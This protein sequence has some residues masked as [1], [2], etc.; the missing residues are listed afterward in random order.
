ML[1]KNYKNLPRN[2]WALSFVSLLNDTSSEII[3]P[4][5]PTF[6]ALTLGASPLAIGAIEG[7]AETTASLLK[8]FSGYLSDRFNSRKLLVFIGYALAS[9]TRPFLSFVSN[10]EQVLLVR[11]TDRV[12]KGIRG[13]PRDA[14]LAA[15]VPY[16]KRGLAFGF[17]RAA[18]HLGAVFG[19]I[20]A[21]VLLWFYAR[22]P[23]E[24]TVN[25]YQN[26][27]LL[28]SIPIV[29]GLFVIVFFVKED[30]KE[31]IS[32]KAPFKF[33]LKEFDGNFK[34][35]LLVIAL[36]TLSNSSDAFLLLRARDAGISPPLL[37]I[38][39][40]FLH[41]SKVVS[42]LIGGSLSDKFGRKKLIFSG[43]IL[44]A[45]VYF[46]FAFVSEAWQAWTLFLIYG[47]YFGL[48]E[49]AEKA[50]V[51][52]LVPADKRGT[53]FG[54]YNLAFGVTV[55]PASLLLG[56]IWSWFGAPA[57]FIFS[58][59]LSILAAIFLLTVSNSNG[60]QHVQ[61]PKV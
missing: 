24:P 36:F 38:L 14:L 12:G 19:P 37:P 40:M 53:A 17:N 60:E 41:V 9:I 59:G 52:D 42:S 25:E 21:S 57:A 13:A 61:S 31:E 27:F 29:I 4:L 49:G 55:F 46:G 32:Q 47:I 54:L 28:A 22:N 48:T 44:Y 3:Y 15:E 51:A 8:L 58:A 7:I 6:L 26:V 23:N 45:L 10:W 56:G 2:V 34:R 35:F 43:W 33:S 1:W 30:G 20:I 39:W 5:L 50:L 18:D 11:L 16:E